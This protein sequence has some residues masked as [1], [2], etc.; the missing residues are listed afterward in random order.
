E[1]SNNFSEVKFDKVVVQKNK[2]VA[3]V[4]FEINGDTK[5]KTAHLAIVEKDLTV[6]V[7][8]GENRGRS[9]HH[10]NVVRKL[11]SINLSDKSSYSIQLPIDSKINVA[12]ASLVIYLQ[13]LDS[14]KIYDAMGADLQQ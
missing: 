11:K 13:D 3:S 5:N 4:A 7:N 9:L 12:N 8:R 14:L 2:A 1:L 6:S 10:D